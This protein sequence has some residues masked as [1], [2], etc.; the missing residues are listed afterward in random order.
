M[1]IDSLAPVPA[2]ALALKASNASNA[3]TLGSLVHDRLGQRT[4][5]KGMGKG[6]GKGSQ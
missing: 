3:I 6:K 2:L 1:T 5:G 4:G